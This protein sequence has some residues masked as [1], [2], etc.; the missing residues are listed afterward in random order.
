MS[1]TTRLLSSTIHRAYAKYTQESH[2]KL[3]QQERFKNISTKIKTLKEDID[4]LRRRALSDE[5]KRKHDEHFKH[6][7]DEGR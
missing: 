6:L 4:E 3:I 2:V 5:E 1:K 7:F